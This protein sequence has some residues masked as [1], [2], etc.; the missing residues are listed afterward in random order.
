MLSAVLFV[1]ATFAASNVLGGPVDCDD[2]NFCTIDTPGDGGDCAHIQINCNDKNLCTIDNCEPNLGCVT[3]TVNCEDS[4]ACTFDSCVPETGCT[5][6]MIS[7]DDFN[8][9]TNDGC[10]DTTG[11]THTP[12]DCD[13][14]S[15]CTT[16]RCDNALG[17]LHTAIS[18]DDSNK[19]TSDTCSPSTGCSH[20]SVDCNDANACTT[21]TCESSTGC[22]HTAVICD[23][24][25]ECTDDSCDGGCIFT[26][27]SC[28]DFDACTIDSCDSKTG[29][30]STAVSC[31]DGDSCTVDSCAPETGCVHQPV[32]CDDDSSCTLDTCDVTTG[33]CVFTPKQCNDFNACTTDSCDATFG[34]TNTIVNCDDSN[35]CTTDSCDPASGC[36]NLPIVCDDSDTCTVD[37]CIADDGCQFDPLPTPVSGSGCSSGEYAFG[38]DGGGIACIDFGGDKRSSA[39]TCP[40]APVTI[41][42]SAAS[43]FGTVIPALTFDSCL[44]AFD[45]AGHMISFSL[46]VGPL[47][48][49]LD[50]ACGQFTLPR[51]FSLKETARKRQGGVVGSNGSGVLLLK[52]FGQGDPHLVTPWGV[53]FDFAGEANAT[54]VLFAA[55]QV[56][57]NMQLAAAGPAVRFMTSIAVL[58]G[59]DTFVFHAG[60][61]V[62]D[63]LAAVKRAL[64][65]H[66]ARVTL[67]HGWRLQMRLCDGVEVQVSA[68]HRGS[69][70]FL[71]VLFVTPGCVAAGGALGHTYDCKYE[72]APESFEWSHS[73]EESFRVAAL[74]TAVAPFSAQSRA[75]CEDDAASG[76]KRQLVGELSHP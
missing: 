45:A 55:P 68:S 12:V 42:G 1:L 71:N 15:V 57:V 10:D 38:I 24:F 3:T 52:A 47:R 62:F 25:D 4:S 37:S 22:V 27:V 46:A 60:M 19:C 35:A 23:D 7:C 70:N 75:P 66:G 67:A 54:Y 6:A 74:T 31:D 9:C 43:Q 13:D 63:K 11:C 14:S 50:E 58:V 76:R 17:C 41:T 29:C 5:H 53:R 34:C 49:S 8:P 20:D 61:H 33:Q 69:F 30:V 64:E 39:S 59:N 32:R 21:D 72:A 73:Q 36:S 48:F 2:F 26:T 44:F 18:C 28:D 40:S 56:Q 65:A 16:D 51:G